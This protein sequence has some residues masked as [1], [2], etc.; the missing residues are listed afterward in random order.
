[1]DA[2]DSL[3]SYARLVMYSFGFQ[4]AYRRGMQTRDQ[5]FLDKV[6]KNANDLPSYLYWLADRSVHSVT[7]TR[8]PWSLAW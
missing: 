2:F 7:S 6:S 8:L 5:L 3:T 4:Q 1:M